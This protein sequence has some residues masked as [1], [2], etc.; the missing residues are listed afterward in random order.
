MRSLA[1]FAAAL[2]GAGRL[3]QAV[4]VLQLY[5]F[6]NATQFIENIAIRR[7]GELL[8]STFDDGRL[9]ALDPLAKDPEPR[10][11]AKVPD[12]TGLTGIAEIEPDMF[13]VS[14]GINN[15][16]DFSMVE[17]S[18]KLVVVD[19]NKVTDGVTPTVKTFFAMIPNARMLNGMA[20]LPY[21]RS[22]LMS[23][24]SK[25]GRVFRTDYFKNG[26]SDVAFEDRK[27]APGKD[28]K[29]A[30]LGIN[31]VKIVHM[32]LYFTNSE[33]QTIGRLRIDEFGNRKGPV[34]EIVRLPA[35]S[36]LMPDDFSMFYNGT[37]FVAAHPNSVL[38]ILPDGTWTALVGGDSAAKLDGPTSTALTRDGK[39]LY[40]VTGGTGSGRGGQVVAVTL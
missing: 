8:L 11:V 2:L 29:L 5:Q 25:N 40:V 16:T 17:G 24:D 14:C 10:V 37:M 39:T 27:L 28:P 19:F 18:A 26:K 4:Q 21:I 13:A 31:G 36:G 30:T 35:S 38:K 3:A 22:V 33:R 15:L 32:W 34:E 1:G 20:P 6:P 9:Y 7:N 12:A 23:A